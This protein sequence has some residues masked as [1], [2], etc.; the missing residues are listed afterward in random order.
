MRLVLFWIKLIPYL[1][2]IYFN[3]KKAAK[4]PFGERYPLLRRTARKIVAINKLDVEAIGIN[5]IPLKDGFLFVGNHQGT[6]DAFV[7]TE[8]CSIPITAVSKE[9]AN[10]I[11]FLSDWYKAMEVIFFNRDSLKD[12]VR[13]ANQLSDYLK[14]GRNVLIFPEGTR[15]RSQKMNEFKPGSF[16]GAI[17][18][19]APIIPF[20]FVN[21]YIPLDSKEKKKKIK[22]VFDQPIHYEEYKD[23]STLDLAK[24]VQARI[25]TMI[26]ENL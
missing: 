7:F 3:A 5:N 26:D 21:A 13:M 16:K 6:T 4:L 1:P 19:K 10:K 17:K 2:W 15:S 22:V 20:A 23:W 14:L 12:A 25:Q 24:E 18:A 8:A 11:P 9:E